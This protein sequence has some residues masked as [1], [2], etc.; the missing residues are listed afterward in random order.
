MSVQDANIAIRVG[1]DV[2]QLRSAMAAGSASVSDFARKSA[3][4]LRDTTNTLAKMGAAAVAAGAALTAAIYAKNSQR[5]DALAKTADATRMTTQQIQALQ[6]VSELGGVAAEDMAKSV[7]RLQSVIGDAER[8]GG[9]AAETF[10]QLGLNLSEVAGM[11]SATQLQTIAAALSNV[12]NQARKAAIAKELFGRQGSKMLGI[13]HQIGNDGLKPT[14]AEL[15]NMGLALSRVDAAKVEAAND[16]FDVARKVIEGA[17]Q[18]LTV[19]L[20]PY[21]EEVSNRLIEAAKNGNGFGDEIRQAI[22]GAVRAAGKFADVLQGL[23]VVFKGV[24]LIAVGFGA[25]VVSVIEAAATVVAKFVDMQI[26]GVN[27]VIG[28]LNKL[29]KVDIATVDPFS[30]SAFV[31]GLHALGDT[32]RDKVGVVR[33][34]LHELAMQEMPS[35][36]V[37]AF[38]NAVA[39]KAE[40]TAQR[41]TAAN[42]MAAI[43]LPTASANDEESGGLDKKTQEQL[44]A[45]QAKYVTEQEIMRGH[46]ETMALIGEEYDARKFASEEEWRGVRLQAE[47]DFYSKIRGLADQG[48]QGVQAVMA[49]RWGAIGAETSGALKSIVGTMATSSRKAFEISKAWAL[50][51]ALISTAQGIAAGVRLGWPMGV[52]AVAWAAANGFAQ[53]NAIRNQKFGGAGGAA[54]SG[55]GTPATAPNPIG[56]GGAASGGGSA[57]DQ[58]AL[59]T[60]SGIEAGKMYDGRHMIAVMQEAINNG[61][62]LRLDGAA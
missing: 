38:L 8:R 35:D 5:I 18:A 6:H 62:R 24:E 32:A 45:L 37:E 41:V 51:D 34:E 54:A 4:Q 21:V 22:E 3:T 16:A 28:A 60:F 52:P 13:L 10:E 55:G 31:Q 15:E 30:E 58:G 20:A 17:G 46:Q 49:A 26:K 39:A 19:E 23:R 43:G 2:T 12:D 33:S 9:A 44:E 27:T 29:P 42:P 48:Y 14:I 7:M 1:G 61:A 36:R 40:E 53:V 50:A 59:V 56:V 25:A 11:D 57:S 47:A